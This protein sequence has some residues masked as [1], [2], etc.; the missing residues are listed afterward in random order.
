M[1][2]K[3]DGPIAWT[4]LGLVWA[5]ALAG[6]ALNLLARWNAPKVY[7]ALYLLLGWAALSIVDKLIHTLSATGLILLAAGGVPG[8]LTEG[9]LGAWSY[10]GRTIYFNST[11]SGTRAISPSG[12]MISSSAAAARQPVGSTIIFM[13]SAKKRI[14]ATS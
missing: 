12:F 4:V 10:D 7:L 2:A 1:L 13:R 5:V 14:V 8:L 11:R 3:L 6:V 9:A